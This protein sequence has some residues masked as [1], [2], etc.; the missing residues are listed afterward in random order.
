MLIKS[1]HYHRNRDIYTYFRCGCQFEASG[2]RRGLLLL[3]PLRR[4][5]SRRS[6][7]RPIGRPSSCRTRVVVHVARRWLGTFR[8][9]ALAAT[10]SNSRCH[11]AA[12]APSRGAKV[13]GQARFG[14][15]ILDRAEAR[16]C[17][18]A[19]AVRA[20]VLV[21]A[22]S[23]VCAVRRV[24]HPAAAAAAVPNVPRARRVPERWS[25]SRRVCAAQ[26]AP[27]ATV[28]CAFAV[29]ARRQLEPTVCT[30]I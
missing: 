3:P 21:A 17:R 29:R 27:R 16:M 2:L 25:R 7:R 28:R 18:A 8:N 11:R 12:A 22:R 26:P 15:K 10:T 5:A 1:R 30:L 6:R 19:A 14:G 13:A 9:R 24:V 23:H 4:L 20:A